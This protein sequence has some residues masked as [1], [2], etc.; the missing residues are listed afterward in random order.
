MLLGI[1]GT[2]GAGKGTI[3]EYLVT[4]KGF[5]HFPARALWEEEL[6]KRGVESN[7]ANM[8]LVANELRALHGDD[9]LVAHYLKK[10][11]ADGSKNAVI[12]SIRTLAEVATL[13][14]NGGVLLLIDADPRV[15]Y[16]RIVA[17]KSA[18]DCVTFEEFTTHEQLEMNDP[19][20]HG[21]QKAKVMEAADYTFHNND[22]VEEL[23]QEIDEFLATHH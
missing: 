18:S 9:Y 23:H 4:H 7:R 5:L 12:E 21:M 16:E 20:P 15:R 1:T 6:K 11:Q 13:K 2:D 14:K 22:S 10:I 19:N 8:R 17:R 3:V